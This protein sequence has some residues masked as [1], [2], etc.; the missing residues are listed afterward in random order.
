MDLLWLVNKMT[1]SWCPRPAPPPPSETETW[2]SRQGGPAL[3]ADDVVV[4]ADVAA[5]MGTVDVVTG[6]K[7]V[8]VGFA[9]GDFV[10]LV[11][12]VA[13]SPVTLI[14]ATPTTALNPMTLPGTRPKG[15]CRI[16]KSP[17]LRN[18][19]GGSSPLPIR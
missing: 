13:R 8:V 6:A 14:A 10:P 19:D 11:H 1:W 18:R 4:L 17:A 3:A 15:R 12:P 7:V 5:V 16:S 9:A 2:P